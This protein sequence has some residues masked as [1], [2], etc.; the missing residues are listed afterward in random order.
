V[1]DR[2]F[3]RVGAQDNITG[4]E[5]TF[6]VE[7]QETAYILNNATKRSLILLDEVGRGTA[8][9]DGI[10][11]AW[12]IT[13]Y[14]HNIIQSKTLFATHYHELNELATRYDKIKNYRAEVIETPNSEN[15]NNTVIF[16]HKIVQGASDHSFGIYVGKIAGLPHS[17][18]DRAAEI[19]LDF[20][21]IGNDNS[22]L[23]NSEI[24]FSDEN[25]INSLSKKHSLKAIKRPKIDDNQLSIF[26]F[27]D[28]ALRDKLRNIDINTITPVQ[29]I[30]LL[31]E[32]IT[33]SNK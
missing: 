30:Q 13:E 6:L 27:R 14:I 8:T 3:T 19:M 9:Y 10:S 21:K 31:E 26:E 12:A 11:I 17:I 23:S 33:M 20:E 2:I 32:L 7:M 15:K 1:I 24:E 25:T 5:S 4:G 29:S 18:I 22:N 28:D 16:T